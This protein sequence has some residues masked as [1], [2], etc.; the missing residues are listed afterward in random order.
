MESNKDLYGRKGGGKLRVKIAI[1]AMG[2]DH[3]PAEIV[4]GA[5][6]AAKEHGVEIVLVGQQSVIRPQLESFTNLDSRVSI[7]DA[8]DVVG[9][10]E[11]AAQ[12]VRDKPGS[13]VVVGMKL[14]RGKGASAFVSAG[15]TGAVV[16]AAL[17]VLGKLPGIQ[18]PALGAL[19]KTQN[20]P[21]LLL[22]SGAN[23]DCRPYYLV[24]FAYLGSVYMNRVWG[25]ANPRIGLLSNGEEEIKGNLLARSTHQLLKGT[26]LNF[27]GNVEGRDIH[28][29]I[30]DVIV[31]DGFTGNVALKASE[32][33]GES[34]ISALSQIMETKIRFRLASLFMRPALRAVAKQV[35]YS[36]YGGAPLLG[37]RGNVIVAHGRS[38]AKAI[39]NAVRL[40]KQTVA[41]GLPQAM[42]E[43]KLWL[44]Q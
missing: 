33:M 11:H 26:K 30:V 44:N 4:K 25:I 1:D 21:V 34:V 3:A 12:A 8:P 40:A 32:G 42:M 36:E 16:C 39:K 19:V 22:D 17:L 15:H 10:G 41:Q 35:D 37:V 31:T 7:I 9:F 29:Q 5:V 24:Q 6:E 43:E 14:L 23:A 20:S 2:G 27:V 38:Q 18:R 13:S 28:R